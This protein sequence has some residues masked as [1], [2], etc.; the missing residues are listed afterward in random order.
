MSPTGFAIA[1]YR[2][3]IVLTAAALV[4]GILGYINMPRQEDPTLPSFGGRV[5]V[6]YPSATPEEIETR[7]LE[8][9]EESIHELEDVEI[10]ESAAADGVASIRAEWI[11]DAD[12]DEAYD[13]FVQRVSSVQGELP[14]D[15]LDLRMRSI[16]PSSVTALQVALH[17]E[18]AS[19]SELEQWAQELE[20]R[21]NTLPD[22][23]EVDLEGE[24]GT[25]IHVRVDPEALAS[26]GLSLVQVSSALASANGD[27]PG[28]DVLASGRKLSIRPNA[29]FED[30]DGI[31][32]TVLRAVDGR[33]VRLGDLATVH[34]GPEDASYL[35]RHQGEP[36]VLVTATLKEGRSVFSLTESA[37]VRFEDFREQ[38]PEHI[39]A[40]MVL[41]QSEDVEA[42]LETFGMSLLQG[43]AIIVLFVALLVG[44]RAALVAISAMLLSVGIS[45][46]L[47]D[48]FGISLQQMSIAGLVVVLGLLVDNAV[49]VFESIL[50][51]RHQG[52]DPVSAARRGADLVASAITSSTATT[53]AAF[54]P[55]L[56]MAGSVGDFTRDIPSV[57][58]V[59]LAV[60]LFVALFVT[61]L[62]ST[63]LFHSEASTR[64]QGLQSR[65]IRVAE[66]GGYARTLDFMQRRPK[67]TIALLLG[68]ALSFLALTP[69]L[70]MN[71]FPRADDKPHFLVRV[72]TPQG[73]NLDATRQQAL[74]VE[75]YLRDHDM[76]RSVTTNVGKGN[77]QSYY[78]IIR[79]FE[80]SNFAELLVVVPREKSLE[81]DEFAREI[82][83][84][85]A[86]APGFTVQT[87]LLVQGPPVGLPV[88]V[89]IKGPNLERLRAHADQLADQLREIPGAINVSHDLRPGPA[90][91][92][93]R[94]DAVQI[95][96]LGLQTAD[97]AR[98]VRLAMAGGVATTMREDD[99]DTDIV[100]RV[101]SEGE[102]SFEDLHRIHIPVPGG[103][104][105]PLSQLTRPELTST[106][107]RIMH[108]DLERSVIVGA[109]TDGRLANAIVADLMPHVRELELDS[110]ESWEIIGEDEER[111]R[112]FM[113]MLRNVI[114]AMG[115][116][117]GIL[118]LQFRSFQL[119]FVIFTSIPVALAGS[120]VGLLLSGWPFGFTAFVGLLALTGI[121][122]NDAIVLVDR[123]NQNRRDGMELSDAVRQGAQSRLQPIILTTL[124]TQ[125][126]LLPLTLFGGSMWG[127]MGWVV[128]GGLGAASLVTLV[129][130]PALYLVIEGANERKHAARGAAATAVVALALALLLPAAAG[131][132]ET[133]GLR[134]VLR[135][136]RQEN[137]DLAA[138]DATV[139]EEARR[140]DGAQSAR[141]PSLNAEGNWVRS[142]G[143]LQTFGIQLRDVQTPE[144]LFG[145]DPDATEDFLTGELRVEWLL[146]SFS[147]ESGI[148]AASL[149][150][151]ARRVG[152]ETLARSLDLRATALF[153]EIRALR[154]EIE[155]RR[156]TQELVERD[157]ED[158]RLRADSGR[159]LRADVLQLEARRA[160]IQAQVAAAEGAWTGARSRLAEIMGHSVETLGLLASDERVGEPGLTSAAAV[161][162]S[163]L[164]RRP[165]WRGQALSIEAQARRV[166]AGSRERWPELV[167]R[168]SWSVLVPDADL[169]LRDDSTQ[170]AAGLRWR[171]FEGGGIGAAVNER[172]AGLRRREHERVALRRRIERESVQAW[173]RHHTAERQLQ[174]ARLQAGAAEEAH[175]IVQLRY[176]EGRETLTRLL[177]AEASLTAARSARVRARAQLEIARAQLRWVAG[178]P[179]VESH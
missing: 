112:A 64:P 164:R 52:K 116:I 113:S 169:D 149:G 137:A 72:E 99:Q 22:V 160:E 77:P 54:S 106:Y 21:W 119:P 131:A 115:L 43:A 59:V 117:Y 19:F 7:V 122:V 136:V 27:L 86:D 24:I 167:A 61:P 36:A 67:T 90:R 135:S 63:R 35:V 128:I 80:Q 102:E 88:S 163:A 53:V 127:P 62:I 147:R 2:F 78:N 76:V 175:R 173:T 83:D 10:I 29:R 25:Q 15:V 162:D 31:R 69:L 26:A 165:E 20:D 68:V 60:S 45:F 156:A 139:D 37:R 5:T 89:R 118:V 120:V 33:P 30:L 132:T 148:D 158:A 57:V 176:H 157:L 133:I 108:T 121:V 126:G 105:V 92:D 155:V 151:Q 50:H 97:V 3:V 44:W 150:L 82:R 49:V 41:D 104:P 174:A 96:K 93:L 34:Y 172:R 13:L 58:S 103:T 98:E 166:Q 159:A 42:R 32:A 79:D 17:S 144:D 46:W 9:L 109:D 141:W 101:A 168:A 18:T 107:A 178:L 74:E 177:G 153:F 100:V 123:I 143:P 124:T 1:N 125:A 71:F 130:V 170:L 110:Q 56:L 39:H 4:L 152:H 111:D 75:D 95:Q 12:K 134:E 23:K 28:G 179:L 47:L 146:W 142:N 66:E 16:K 138:S 129:L 114:T 70:G 84:R 154:E 140:L 38:L 40:T 161:A 55:M 73:T 171:L 81:I 48:A 8:P 145:F 51:E 91:L 6:I 94:L 14:D 65:L 85:F 11:D 87:K